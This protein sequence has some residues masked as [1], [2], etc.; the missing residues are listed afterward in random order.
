M[1]DELE[2]VDGVLSWGEESE[3]RVRQVPDRQHRL[4]NTTSIRNTTVMMMYSP[5]MR[6]KAAHGVQEGGPAEWL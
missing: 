6:R 1:G 2:K 3:Q 4:S 5:E